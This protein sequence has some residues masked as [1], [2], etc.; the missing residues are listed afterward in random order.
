M[1]LCLCAS[2][3][4]DLTYRVD[5]L[6]VA[7]TNRVREVIQR[8]GGKAINVARVLHL[9]GED[10]RLL[11]TAGGD[12]GVEL[13][14]G[15]RSCGIPH[16]VVASA[17]PTRRTVAVVDAMSDEVTMLNEPATIG[18]WIGFVAASQRAV[19]DADVVV[20]SG[21]LPSDVPPD[22][23]AALIRY[24]AAHDTPVVLDTSG[25]A[26]LAALGARPTVV[27]PNAAELQEVTHQS[28]PVSA[29][30]ELADRWQARVV[31]SLGADG[32]VAVDTDTTWRARPGVIVTGNP[33]GAGDAV[34]AGLARGL[35]S[36]ATPE[37]TLADCLAL[38][39]SSV[40]AP[41]AGELDVVDYERHRSAAVVETM[42]RVSR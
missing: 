26:L 4:L 5:R 36:G 21:S 23:F 29:A 28:D 25:P 6:S 35:A 30:R 7:G 1:I 15:L 8:P 24:A 17:A 22:G 31:A 16:E 14:N 13:V 20:I 42:D 18:E 39:A 9:L 3:A 38:A 11:T 33:T 40:L 27:K 10:V 41:A 37:A 2:P 34:V 19:M 32:L 12:T